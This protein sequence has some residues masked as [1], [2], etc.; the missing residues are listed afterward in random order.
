MNSARKR[1]HLTR[2]NLVFFFNP[3]IP[4]ILNKIEKRSGSL[5]LNVQFRCRSAAEILVYFGTK[6]R[7][8]PMRLLFLAIWKHAFQPK[9]CFNGLKCCTNKILLCK[10]YALES[11]IHF[12]HGK[13]AVQWNIEQAACL[14][15]RVSL[16]RLTK[17]NRSLSGRGQHQTVW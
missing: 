13:S 16:K 9:N 3:K 14:S 7:Q 6:S 4:W 11:D 12:L 15:S 1:L 17:V 2:D 5:W 10:M 8:Y